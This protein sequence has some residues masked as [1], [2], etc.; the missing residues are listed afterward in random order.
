[1]MLLSLL[2]FLTQGDDGEIVTDFW[3][4]LEAHINLPIFASGRAFVPN[5][6]DNLLCQVQC[7]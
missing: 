7:H 5:V 1:M 2:M 4:N 3:D 6:V